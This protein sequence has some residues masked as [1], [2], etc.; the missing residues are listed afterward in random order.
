[1]NADFH[2]VR[3]VYRRIINAATE[4]KIQ[5]ADINGESTSDEFRSAPV[6]PQNLI[7]AN[8]L[9]VSNVWL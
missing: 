2:P 6:V 7:R 1:L 3:A 9:V 8:S 5:K 4:N